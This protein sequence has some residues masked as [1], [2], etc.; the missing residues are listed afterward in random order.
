M[1]EEVDEE[2]DADE[3]LLIRCSIKF[4]ASE[5]CPLVNLRDTVSNDSLSILRYSRKI[6]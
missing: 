5:S 4:F 1:M 3:P 2:L 6:A